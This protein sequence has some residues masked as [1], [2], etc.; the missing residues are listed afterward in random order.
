MKNILL[1]CMLIIGSILTADEMLWQEDFAKDGS[2]QDNGYSVFINNPKDNFTVK[3]KEAIFTC[4]NAPYKGLIVQKKVQLAPQSEFTF[5]A[6]I[7]AQGAEKFS[8]FALK[9]ELGNSVISFRDKK[10]WIHRPKT[11][12]WIQP[13]KIKYNVW[14]KYK[15]RFDAANRTAEYYIDDMD[16][17]VFVD[18]KSDFDPTANDLFKI[19]NYGLSSGT[20]VCGLRNIRYTKYEKQVSAENILFEEKFA[21]DGT[22]E[23]NGFKVI[24]NNPKDTFTVENGELHMIC[25]NVP[26]KGTTITKRVPTPAQCEIIFDANTYMTGSSGHYNNFSIKLEFGNLLIAFN[27]GQWLCHIP[28]KNSWNLISKIKN[29]TWNTF[30][31]RLDANTKRAEFFVNDL[32]IPVFVDESC[33]YDPKA[34]FVLT[35]GNYGLAKGSI[36]SAIR[37]F[38]VMK[39]SQQDNAQKKN[40]LNGTMLF[41][42]MD[43][44][45]YPLEKYAEKFG[46]GQISKFFFETP[47]VNLNN[48]SNKYTISPTP[49]FKPATMPKCVI[50]ADIP[51]DAI[52]PYAQKNLL[53]AINQGASLLIFNGLFTLNKGNFHKTAFEKILPVTVNDPWKTPAAKKGAKT[54]YINKTLALAAK[55]VGK[56]KVIIIMTPE[57]GREL[58]EKG[59]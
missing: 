31:I 43:M 58:L 5:E 50:M 55:N 22:P 15:I 10:L 36:K 39:I 52:P 41:V 18:E 20:V 8:L 45:K 57:G 26:Y 25:S 59:I 53:E 40:D 32:T 3:N 13:G 11:N 2:M 16:I 51:L 34:K 1:I 46:K 12:D 23:N 7:A 33:E 27:K 35:I 37:N 21:V 54:C 49:P 19:G 29:N 38:R 4:T 30:K 24:V 42:G 47:S 14:Q 6:K 56:G 28:S 17:P 48:S 44:D 9:M